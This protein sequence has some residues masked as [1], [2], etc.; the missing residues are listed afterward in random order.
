[1]PTPEGW[2]K[3][4]LDDV[5]DY[6]GDDICPSEVVHETRT[7]KW[8]KKD[9]EQARFFFVGAVKLSQKSY[10]N[11]INQPTKRAEMRTGDKCPPIPLKNVI[12]VTNKYIN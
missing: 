2:L 10:L 9:W 6:W 11:E 8:K 1:M 3:F 4:T 12:S 7:E 5:N